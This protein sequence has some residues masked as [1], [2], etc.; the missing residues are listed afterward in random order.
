M[1]AVTILSDALYT[2]R[3]CLRLSDRLRYKS[4]ELDIYS[5]ISRVVARYALVNTCSPVSPCESS[6][7]PLH[8]PFLSEAYDGIQTNQY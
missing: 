8:L 2:L 7:S 6:S 4:L 1:K 5:S 3:R